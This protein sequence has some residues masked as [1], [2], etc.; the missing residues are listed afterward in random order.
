MPAVRPLPSLA[1]VRPEN[2]LGQTIALVVLADPGREGEG[3]VYYFKDLGRARRA[4][5]R[6]R[7]L[8]LRLWA[9]LLPPLEDLRAPASA[10]DDLRPLV[11]TLAGAF[12]SCLEEIP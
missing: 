7:H 12:V 4:E 5:E 1:C 11:H 6:L 2:G 8:G 10:L 9:M 3:A